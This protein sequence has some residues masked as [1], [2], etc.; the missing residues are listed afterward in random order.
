[1]KKPYGYVWPTSL[2]RECIC[3]QFKGTRPF[4]GRVSGCHE[5]KQNPE[6]ARLWLHHPHAPEDDDKDNS[7]LLGSKVHLGIGGVSRGTQIYCHQ[8]S[9]SRADSAVHRSVLTKLGDWHKKN[10]DGKWFQNLISHFSMMTLSG[11]ITKHYQLSALSSRSSATLGQ[12]SRW[13]RVQSNHHHHQQQKL[14][15]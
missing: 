12:G 15:F 8:L 7:Q 4:L 10:A 6:V 3:S 14:T 13:G 11:S 1:M 2:A 9:K 5:E